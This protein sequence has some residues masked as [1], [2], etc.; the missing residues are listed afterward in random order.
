MR[1]DGRRDGHDEG[2][3]CFSR[4]CEG[5][6]MSSTHLTW[7]PGITPPQKATSTC[8]FPFAAIIFV[9]KF[10]LVVVGGM[11]FLQRK[12]ACNKWL[13]WTWQVSLGTSAIRYCHRSSDVA[14]DEVWCAAGTCYNKEQSV[15]KLLK[16]K[17]CVLQVHVVIRNSQLRSCW[18]WSVVCCR[19]ML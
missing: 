4:L 17:C 16:M 8:V 15:K 3:R 12:P 11:E 18:R 9:S 5:A 1:T 10:F 19:Y 14:E 7:L 13:M 2:S 6:C